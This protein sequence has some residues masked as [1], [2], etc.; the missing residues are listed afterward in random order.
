MSSDTVCSMISS[1]TEDAESHPTCEDTQQGAILVVDR[2]AIF[3]HFK[4]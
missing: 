1:T 3:E 2:D 4:E